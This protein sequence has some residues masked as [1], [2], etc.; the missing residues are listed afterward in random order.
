MANRLGRGV[1]MSIGVSPCRREVRVAAAYSRPLLATAGHDVPCVTWC[2]RRATTADG[3]H[4]WEA[5]AYEGGRNGDEV[6]LRGMEDLSY[7]RAVRFSTMLQGIGLQRAMAAPSLMGTQRAFVAQV[8]S[9]ELPL[10][11]GELRMMPGFKETA[12][13]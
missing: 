5:K 13:T 11:V 6:R 1:V 4:V 8:D 3:E 7:C 9:V 10:T 12:R 2:I